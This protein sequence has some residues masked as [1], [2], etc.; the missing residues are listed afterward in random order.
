M[1]CT[2]ATRQSNLNIL[3]EIAPSTKSTYIGPVPNENTFYS[4]LAR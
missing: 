3:A 4:G 1:R 2:P